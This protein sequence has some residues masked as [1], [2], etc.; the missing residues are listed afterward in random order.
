[1]PC[2]DITSAM[3]LI[4]LTV[5][6]LTNSACVHF[7]LDFYF[8]GGLHCCIAAFQVL[9]M[10]NWISARAQV[11]WSADVRTQSICQSVTRAVMWC[12]YTTYIIMSDQ[13]ATCSATTYGSRPETP[14]LDFF[15][16][17]LATIL[18][19]TR[20]YLVLQMLEHGASEK[21]GGLSVWQSE[22]V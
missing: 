13:W 11:Y 2:I 17:W 12:G 8:L 1:M 6:A 19:L 22:F 14:R 4:Q 10:Q 15:V 9:K 5:V 7:W 18:Y 16:V 20:V 21:L 3:Q